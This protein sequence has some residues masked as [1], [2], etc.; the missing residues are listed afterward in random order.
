[1]ANTMALDMLL[2]EKGGVCKMF[3]TVPPQMAA[4]PRP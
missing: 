2:A 1:M 3:G 4:S